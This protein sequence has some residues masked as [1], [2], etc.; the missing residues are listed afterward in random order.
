LDN[1]Q[2]EILGLLYLPFFLKELSHI[3]ITAAEINAFW[4]MELAFKIDTLG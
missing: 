3:V 4:A 1:F 2:V